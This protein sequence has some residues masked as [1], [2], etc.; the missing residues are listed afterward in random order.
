MDEHLST[1]P[2]HPARTARRRTGLAVLGACL[3]VALLGIALVVVSRGDASDGSPAAAP[4]TPTTTPVADPAA[5]PDGAPV[6]ETIPADFPLA[7]GL[8]E[9]NE[10]RRP[11]RVTSTDQIT[12]IGCG[13]ELT[14]SGPEVADLAE[15]RFSQPEDTRYC[16]LALYP[17]AGGAAVALDR[18]T[19]RLRTCPA[20]GSQIYGEVET[21]YGPDSAVFATQYPA[22]DG[23]T[24][25]EQGVLSPGLSS[26]ELVRVEN[27]L[28]V[29]AHD[30]EGG[31]SPEFV[32]GALAYYADEASGVLA[33][34][35]D[36]FGTGGSDTPPDSPAP[37]Y[38]PL[39]AGWPSDDVAEPGDAYGLKGPSTTMDAF[40]YSACGGALP[41]DQASGS[42]RATWANVE[43]YRT[44]ELLTFDDAPAAVG[45]MTKARVHFRGCPEEAGANGSILI[46]T[47]IPSGAGGES[48]A[49]AA[50]AEQDGRPAI[51]LQV[52]QLIRLGS[53]V[54]LDTTYGEGGASRDRPAENRQVIDEMTDASA[55]VVSAMCWF[56]EAGC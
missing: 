1:Q 53:A 18:L 20:S 49:V 34:M 27:A 4:D 3:V 31:G 5:Q 15:V 29:I 11:V 28:L 39:S 14:I 7:D 47:V 52:V 10:D 16:G 19:G 8:P 33:S 38:F 32:E 35:H 48:F 2:L 50:N 9:A 56:T 54:L 55:P 21:P 42:L 45:F 44:R 25:E 51:G 30:G 40:D 12:V 41:L 46:R 43:D 17:S 13:E 37:S 26:L 23:S 36:V 6:L 24:G 22:F